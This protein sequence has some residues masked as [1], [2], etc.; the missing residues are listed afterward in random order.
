M[1]H[2]K[3]VSRNFPLQDFRMPYIPDLDRQE[4]PNSV[5][6][7][8]VE[9]GTTL[10]LACEDPEAQRRVAGVLREGWKG[11]VGV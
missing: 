5:L 2:Q 3:G 9:G 4:L 1:E 11:A 6:L 10:Q 7:D 8:F